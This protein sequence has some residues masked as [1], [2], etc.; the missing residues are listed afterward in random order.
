MSCQTQNF[1]LG[2][3]NILIGENRPQVFCIV[4]RKD[5]AGS[6]AGKY[7]VFHAPVTQAK[8]YVWYEIVGNTNSVDPSIPNA[9][10]HKVT[11][12]A[13]DT[14]AAVATKTATVL[15]SL[16]IINSA[17]ATG[18]H[19][20]VKFQNNGYAYEAR[21]ALIPAKKTGFQIT[22]SKFGS[23][24]ADAGPTQ[25]DITLSIEQQFVDIT[26]P[27]T[28]DFV[29]GQIRRGVTVSMSFELKSTAEA[30]IR[31]ALNYYGGTYVTDDADSAVL[32]GYGSNN[33]FKSF[34]DV[35]VPVILREPAL[36]A[37]ND[38]S[39]DITL[40]KAKVALGEVTFSAESELV[41]PIE[42]TGYL[43]QSK[44]SGLNLLKF[45]DSTKL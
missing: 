29:L 24:Q 17:V 30:N 13:N 42:V 41:L 31:E 21:D 8:H 32:S 11:I 33:I 35:A 25:G 28:G 12:L 36:A 40:V 4:T 45:G 26:S 38:P 1:Q 19:I 7:F 43:D 27:Q 39:R 10:M 16:A 22:V 9:T 18:N 14:A 44:F 20:E 15:S 6:L 23:V 2:V 37:E 3:R 5:V 34:D